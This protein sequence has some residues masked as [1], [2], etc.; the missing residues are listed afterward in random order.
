MQSAAPRDG[1]HRCGQGVAA[2]PGPRDSR[3]RWLSAWQEKIRLL[4]ASLHGAP[5]FLCSPRSRRLVEAPSDSR[6]G[7]VVLAHRDRRHRYHRRV[8]PL[9]YEYSQTVLVLFT[10]ECTYRIEIGFSLALFGVTIWA[11]VYHRGTRD[12]NRLMC[13][14]TVLLFILSTLVR[15]ASKPSNETNSLYYT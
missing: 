4:T 8:Y 6:H 15:H 5:R 13:T 11:L 12:I 3:G 7:A 9:W 2:R 14:A 1:P 10:D